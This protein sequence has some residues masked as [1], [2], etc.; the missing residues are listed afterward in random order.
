M[1][2]AIRWLLASGLTALL[3]PI[4]GALD[5]S[6]GPQPTVVQTLPPA[7]VLPVLAAGHRETCAD[8]LEIRATTFLLGTMEAGRRFRDEDR[9][10]AWKLYEGILT[11]DPGDAD[12]CWRGAL[13]LG[14]FGQR[15]DASIALLNMGLGLPYE[16]G[17][18]QRIKQ[19]GV[20]LEHP[21]RWR[22]FFEE[23]STCFLLMTARA[24]NAQE[25]REWEKRAGELWVQAAAAG[26]PEPHRTLLVKAGKR[27]VEVGLD[28]RSTLE[29]EIR[30]WDER[31]R[32][33]SNERVREEALQRLRE[34]DSEY[35]ALALEQV[36][37]RLKQRG[38]H[39]TCL[40]ELLAHRVGPATLQDPLGYGY[41]LL[42]D[43]HVVSPGAE[44][45]RW[46]ARLEPRLQQLRAAGERPDLSRLLAVGEALPSY[47]LAEIDAEGVRVRPRQPWEMR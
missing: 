47:L 1:T 12:A 40:E 19:P 4:Q 38:V 31:A 10:H 13:L 25:R 34:L 6:K 5:R 8:L 36:V 33:A 32:T 30:L 16:W 9:D 3:F 41:L 18:E 24:R 26:A 17:G 39:V 37:E 15:P 44:A 46:E 27:L 28:R 29:Q 20:P 22:L 45:A 7:A 23:G 2:S 21:R 14:A 35:A 42:E 11:L 43:G